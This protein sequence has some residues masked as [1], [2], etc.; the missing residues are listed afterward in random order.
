METLRERGVRPLEA[1]PG[2]GFSGTVVALNPED[3]IV[4]MQIVES[5]GHSD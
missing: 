2:T 1:E 5:N 3:T 4:P